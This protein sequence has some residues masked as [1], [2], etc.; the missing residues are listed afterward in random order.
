[1][2]SSTSSNPRQSLLSKI[3]PWA[4]KGGYALA[5]QG[6]ISGSNFLISI[7]L[8]RWLTRD[9]YGAYAVA[10]GIF[11]LL[12]VLYQSLVLEPMSVFGGSNYR[13][14]LRE[15]LRVL[16][17][18][19]F[20][21]CGVLC[22]ALGIWVGVAY[23]LDPHSALP[24]ALA[25]VT[26]ASPLVLIFGLA[27]R[28]FY[29]EL[30]PASAALG[31]LWYCAFAMAG[32]WL[33]FHYG[34]LSAFSAFVAIGAAALAT[35]LLL[36]RHLRANLR[37]RTGHIAFAEVCR[38]HWRYGRWALIANVASWVPAYLFYPILSHAAGLVASGQLRALMNLAAPMQ[39]AQT[40]M[41]LLFLPYAS[42]LRGEGGD[43][44]AASLNWKI[45]LLAVTGA[46]AYWAIIVL[47]KTSVFHLLYSGKYMEVAAYLPFVS[48]GAILWAAS[49]GP[50]VVLRALQSPKLVFI[51]YAVGTAASLIIGIPATYRYG[52]W[53][54]ILGINVADLLSLLLMMFLLRRRTREIWSGA[55]NRDS[56]S[57]GLTPGLS[58]P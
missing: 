36:L 30:T 7:L 21:L 18:L 1:M 3:L 56:P 48:V 38:E 57:A 51:A 31:A 29:L 24:L 58:E 53:G 46:T 22:G 10:F 5:D 39:Q 16:I 25:G 2:D 23:K 40:A 41:A 27:R 9:G 11:V 54:A 17:W 43:R 15:Y 55:A 6:L 28:A 47:F 26:I 34:L 42:R 49:F 50:T 20:S 32:L 4:K 44:K 19:H 37:P 52:L 8:A 35:S 45:S 33:A 13:N 12:T 14:N